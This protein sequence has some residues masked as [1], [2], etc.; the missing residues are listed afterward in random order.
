MGFGIISLYDNNSVVWISGFNKMQMPKLSRFILETASEDIFCIVL[1]KNSHQ[2]KRQNTIVLNS[3]FKEF[4]I[5]FDGS[6]MALG[7]TKDNKEVS[8]L[9][10]KKSLVGL[11]F[12][13]KCYHNIN[14]PAVPEKQLKQHH[15]FF[16][17]YGSYDM[18]RF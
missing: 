14:R 2:I 10:G 9:F 3:S 11:E 17:Y 7:N 15:N 16:K 18:L 13:G 12:A 5:R 6:Y 1:Q 4:H 8:E